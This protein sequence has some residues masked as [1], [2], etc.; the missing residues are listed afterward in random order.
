MDNNA[1]ETG[2]QEIKKRGR[3]NPRA[4]K[5]SKLG[6][7]MY[8]FKQGE[9]SQLMQQAIILNEWSPIDLNSDEEVDNRINEYWL[10]CA[11][12][13]LRPMVSGL[14]LALGIDRATLNAWK[15]GTRRG[16]LSSSRVDIIKKAYSILEYMWE[17]YMTTGKINPASGC[18]I[19]KNNFG[20]QDEIKIVAAPEK[21]LEA[22][23]TPEEISRQLEQD[24]PID[25]DFEEMDE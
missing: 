3:G 22:D 24:I 1:I 17:Q 9:I 25:V 2:L 23:R 15:N 16:K 8:E 7:R 11:E 21:S 6:D 18:F 4:Y 5:N 10:F 13:D 20:Y 12:R 19:G 14:A